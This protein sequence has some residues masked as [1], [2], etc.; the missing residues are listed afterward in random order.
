MA[1]YPNHGAEPADD[2][3]FG[4]LD[5]EAAEQLLRG[6]PVVPGHWNAPDSPRG[7]AEAERLAAFL[8][9][10]SRAGEQR[11]GGDGSLPGEEAALAAFRASRSGTATVSRTGGRSRH[12]ES[13][14][15]R[16]RPR[17][18]RALA[19]VALT[20]CTAGGVAVATGGVASLTSPFTP[21]PTASSTPT[22]EHSDSS[23]SG[24]SSE[25][26]SGGAS[27]RA[28]GAAP[29][30]EDSDKDS[31]PPSHD[32]S[33][34]A[35]TQGS[36]SGGATD[37]GQGGPGGGPGNG[38]D[39]S[40]SEALDK[41]CH[42]Y[43]NAQAGQGDEPDRRAMRDLKKA[44]GSEKAITEFCEKRVGSTGGTNPSGPPVTTP[45][46]GSEESSEPSTGGPTDSGYAP[47]ASTSPTSQESPESGS[48]A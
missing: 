42:A 46:S 3:R 34:P 36:T 43:L 15:S 44:A 9:T 37:P 22:G 5:E 16:F 14:A 10:A 13:G 38:S 32:G 7:R 35:P 39:P 21:S 41:L 30:G 23:G 24:Q 28:D 4:W 6:G 17:P 47:T 8:Q 11:T 45:P 29:Q 40:Q 25:Q 12:A 19:A 27:G 2:D 31:A 33:S 1:D 18:V 26:P 20:L 48:G